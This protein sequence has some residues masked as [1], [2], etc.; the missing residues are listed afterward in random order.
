MSNAPLATPG[1]AS[2]PNRNFA[3]NTV[4]PSPA[5][6]PTKPAAQAKLAMENII[7]ALALMGMFGKTV[8]VRVVNLI[9]QT[10][11]SVHCITVTAL[12]RKIN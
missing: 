12:A 7:T 11:L 4:S 9:I 5:P 6:E 8:L 2:N 10:V 1:L 3:M